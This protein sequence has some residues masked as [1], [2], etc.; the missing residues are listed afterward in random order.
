M[1]NFDPIV[2]TVVEGTDV[3]VVVVT[4]VPHT[5][6]YTVTIVAEDITAKGT[7]EC[8]VYIILVYSI[9]YIVVYLIDS[10]ILLYILYVH[11]YVFIF[12][13][14]NSLFLVYSCTFIYTYNFCVS[15]YVCICICIYSCIVYVCIHIFCVFFIFL[16]ILIY[17][18]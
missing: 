18:I 15:L 4:S 9:N 17:C 16:Y 3:T 8:Y 6:D 7:H 5:Q 2:Y 13:C 11:I 10:C 12:W 14:T 1:V